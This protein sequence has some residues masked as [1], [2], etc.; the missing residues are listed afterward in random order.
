MTA[1]SKIIS[2]IDARYQMLD[3]RDKERARVLGFGIFFCA[4]TAFALTLGI[5][6]ARHLG[7]IAGSI[8]GVELGAAVAGIMRDMFDQ[9]SG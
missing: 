3:V 5:E 9:R 4:A 7:P 6:S 2:R 1:R 8:A